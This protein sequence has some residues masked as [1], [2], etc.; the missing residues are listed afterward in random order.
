MIGK[1][2]R[3]SYCPAM[4]R[5]G[6]QEP[7][8]FEHAVQIAAPPHEVLGAFFDPHLLRRWWRV[9]A[10]VTTPRPF[11]V[12]A[13]QWPVAPERDALLG[14]LGGAFYGT[15][16]DYRDGREFLLA[17][18]YWLPPEGDPIG[19]MALH[20]SCEAVPGGTRLLLTQSGCD[21]SPRWHR[22]YRVIA[23]GW[24]EA[25][26]ALKEHMEAR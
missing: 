23:G 16:I 25:L 18:A 4:W 2:C 10:S 17:D 6:A 21:A 20:V 14:P 13:L 8:S 22:F 7:S 15:I 11:G 26:G 1:R 3:V 5:V 24:R 12:Y 19:P 9:D